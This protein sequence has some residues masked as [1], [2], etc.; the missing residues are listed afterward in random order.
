[1]KF[2]WIVS[3][4]LI[5]ITFSSQ[6]S[7]KLGFIVSDFTYR[8]THQGQF[9]MQDKAYMQGVKAQFD[10]EQ[11]NLGLTLDGTY[12]WGTMAYTSEKSG[13]M[14]GHFNTILDTRALM[15]YSWHYASWSLQP[16]LGYGYHELI[17]D[18]TNMYT[19]T[20]HVGYLRTQRYH[21]VPLG[22]NIQNIQVASDIT[23]GIRLEYDYFL[24]GH[25]TTDMRS[26]P[27]HGVKNY[28][29]N[30]G[31]GYRAS[32]MFDYQQLRVEPF[33]KYWKIDESDIKERYVVYN[34]QTYLER[35]WE[36]NNQ[37]IEFGIVFS[38]IVF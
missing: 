18:S 27:N 23:L 33:I 5:G 36:P 16:F 3:I 35:S 15:H 25:N 17:D 31:Y 10:Y 26:I 14:S 30:K 19:S 6:A 20:G 29:Q 24:S 38:Y 32:L 22:L 9:I 28:D 12:Q 2:S 8:E 7:L 4:L 1:M 11:K 34:N 13:E 21:Y 37:T